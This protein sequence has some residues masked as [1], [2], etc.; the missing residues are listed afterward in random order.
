[1]HVKDRHVFN[2][3]TYFFVL[4]IFLFCYRCPHACNIC[5]A[6][7]GQMSNDVEMAAFRLEDR[8]SLLSTESEVVFMTTSCEKKKMSSS[9]CNICIFFSSCSGLC[10]CERYNDDVQ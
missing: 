6:P 2:N 10:L 7:D 9:F 1:M 4:I 3:L 8:A 5:C